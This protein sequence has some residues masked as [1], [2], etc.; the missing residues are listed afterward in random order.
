MKRT[1]YI[2]LGMLLA[3]L[4]VVC[5]SVFYASTLMVEREVM[6][7][8]VGG[9]IKKVGLPPCKVIEIEATETLLK[10]KAGEEI[11]VRVPVADNIPLKVIQAASEG[12]FTYAS[13]MDEFM[14]MKSSGDTLRIVLDFPD[15]KLEERFQKLHR[16]RFHSTE[17]VLALPD[18]VVALDNRLRSQKTEIEG[19]NRDSLSLMVQANA[20][21]NRCNFRSLTVRKGAWVFESGKVDNLHLHLDFVNNWRVEVD[22]FHID[23]EYLYATNKQWCV[24]EKDECSKA[25]WIP[26]S[27]EAV[28]NVDLK[29]GA[30][31]VLK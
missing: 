4:F 16:L 25:V 10:S 24:L 28:L 1:T 7:L 27:K 31:M 9:D 15:E 23:T 18:A 13:G 11:R 14:T 29:S 3:G 6:P 17:M 30:T 8:T 26:Q 12:S 21:I 20:V 22:S 5:G 19:L 2:I